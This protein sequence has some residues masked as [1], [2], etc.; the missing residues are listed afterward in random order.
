M[1]K[2]FPL[3]GLILLFWA[4][5]LCAQTP[6]SITVGF[7]PTTT[8]SKGPKGFAYNLYEGTTAGGES[9]TPVN[10]TPYQCTANCQ[11]ITT[12]NLVEGTTYYLYIKTVDL[13][14][15][16]NMSPAS[17][18]VSGMIPIVISIPA[19]PNGLTITIK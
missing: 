5:P 3:I 18:E 8:V 7:T 2:L 19:A 10:S 13:D 1:K 15:P 4:A 12:A 16:P 14:N 9:S 6:H 11:F 17:A